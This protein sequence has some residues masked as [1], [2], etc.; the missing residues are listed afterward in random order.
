MSALTPP[1]PFSFPLSPCARRPSYM[2]A[3]FSTFYFLPFYFLAREARY[4]PVEYVFP[5]RSSTIS[6]LKI[7]TLTPMVPN[8]VLA[9]EVA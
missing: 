9:V 5:R 2:S 6:P 7:Q 1:S 3:S 4:A 8:V